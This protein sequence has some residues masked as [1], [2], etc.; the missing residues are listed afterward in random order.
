MV[1]LD[2]TESGLLHLR[3]KN[4][5]LADFLEL[6]LMLE[7]HLNKTSD[8]EAGL[9]ENTTI[10]IITEADLLLMEPTITTDMV[11]PHMVPSLFLLPCPP[12]ISSAITPN[13]EDLILTIP[14]METKATM[15]ATTLE[16]TLKHQ[17]TTF[18]NP[19]ETSPETSDLT[20]LN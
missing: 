12:E 9:I 8:E 2:T 10:E 6:I 16:C 14:N 11:H 3:P 19:L 17:A 7:D 15:E 5:N 4:S 13:T 18:S 20:P 1:S